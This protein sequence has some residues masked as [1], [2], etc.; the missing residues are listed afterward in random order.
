MAHDVFIS[1]ASV[2]KP[3]A[4]AICATLE[5]RQVRCWIGPRDV[6]TG[7]EYR[8][9]NLG[10]VR[11]GR[12]LVLVLSAAS[13][14]S[15]DAAQEVEAAMQ[16]GIPIVPFRVEDVRLSAEM[17]YLI[18]SQHWLDA[19]T[20]PMEAHLGKLAAAMDK[21]LSYSTPA[22]ASPGTPAAAKGRRGSAIRLPLVAIAVAVLLIMI[23]LVAGVALLLVHPPVGTD[24]AVPAG[25]GKLVN[26]LVDDTLE[27]QQSI[28]SV[29]SLS[30]AQLLKVPAGGFVLLGTADG[31]P[32]LYKL[33]R[34]GG[35]EWNRSY[36]SPAGL[37]IN[38]MAV[39]PDGG[40][41]L[42]G[43]A[44]NKDK[45]GVYLLR[46]DGQ[47]SV[48]W[49]AAVARSSDFLVSTV[50]PAADGGFLL[51][52]TA[53]NRSLNNEYVYLVRTGS[54]GGVQWT[55]TLGNSSDGSVYTLLQA[56]DGSFI[57]LGSMY[58]SDSN[59]SP[60]LMKIDPQGKLVWEQDYNVDS[61][62]ICS[63]AL[64][65]P[66]GGYLLYGREE[67]YGSDDTGDIF[68]LKVDGNGNE[69]WEGRYGTGQYD[70]GYD[71]VVTMNGCY[72]IVATNYT[73]ETNEDVYVALLNT[74]GAE[75]WNHTYGGP[76][77]D[78]VPCICED[79]DG[80]WVVAATTNSFGNDRS[81]AW[82]FKI[83]PIT[84]LNVTDR[85]TNAFGWQELLASP[86]DCEGYSIIPSADGNFVIG[87]YSA[88][89]NN[90]Y[91]DTCLAKVSPNGS[92]LWSR[93]Y[94]GDRND[95]CNGVAGTSDGGYI[96]AG[97]AGYDNGNQSNIRLIKTDSS[98]KEQWETSIYWP[99]E[100]SAKAVLQASDGGYVFTG[101][102]DNYDNA[103]GQIN[104]ELMLAKTDGTGNLLWYKTYGRPGVGNTI[105]NAPD[106]GYI[107]AGK[108]IHPA[109]GT[110]FLLIRTDA[111]GNVRVNKTNLGNA[112]DACNGIILTEDGGY[113]LAG[114][115]VLGDNYTTL[116][117]KLN[118]YGYL[119]WNKFYKDDF[120]SGA[121]AITP[122]S[123]DRYMITG[124][125]YPPGDS[126]SHAFA[127]IIAANG[128]E[129]SYNYDEANG[130]SIILSTCPTGDGNVMATGYTKDADGVEK[131]YVA[132]LP[133]PSA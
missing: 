129:L 123:G 50:L 11:A 74:R 79:D 95:W 17:E 2:D 64:A 35:I 43:S 29:T 34:Q 118:G 4:D 128:T 40:Y 15:A 21:L 18:S 102:V 105:I 127:M 83:R 47:G 8:D 27:W 56:P 70:R 131:I 59:Y 78:T 39:M 46:T 55:S 38:A 36:L 98:G 112:N 103:T 31:V 90:Y 65:T 75:L 133:V 114:R 99:Y 45:A 63:K 6:P 81:A 68:A 71:A 51:G 30:A 3:V 7:K 89:G 119:L 41:V 53:A 49:N 126:V 97:A 77:K 124:Y 107:V 116:V 93:T 108:Y 25:G 23:L 72:A 87:G 120:P 132:R 86:G 101:Y 52:G 37:V 82:L 16:G 113:L 96:L 104:D 109:G 62:D 10:A 26:A 111:D 54:D 92:L 24:K 122:L 106:G 125:M 13:N 73:D 42:A 48:L 5:S 80:G 61:R 94:S 22:P 110:N 19:M 84:T 91:I 69:Q 57:V 9:V 1:Y 115:S 44:G 28:G 100:C 14:T 33:D 85:Q 117:T 66:D 60:T 32:C 121:Y 88:Y 76:G 12:A 58:T 20:Q 130:G 67:N